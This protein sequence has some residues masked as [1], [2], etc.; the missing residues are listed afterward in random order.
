MF[1]HIQDVIN[2]NLISISDGSTRHHSKIY[3]NFRDVKMGRNVYVE[4][5][6]I[7][8]L[9]SI[10]FHHSNVIKQF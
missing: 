4:I 1:H 6:K 8:K 7:Q 2:H 3:V 5:I 9:F 10:I